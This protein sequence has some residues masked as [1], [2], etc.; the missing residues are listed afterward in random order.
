MPDTPSRAAQLGAIAFLL[1]LPCVL[2]PTNTSTAKIMSHP[3]LRHL[4]HISYS[5]FCC[6]VLVLY[7]AAPRLGFELFQSSPVLLFG[8]I[9]G[10]SLFVS[11]VLY[12]C[13]E[14]PFL[15]LKSWRSSKPKQSTPTANATHP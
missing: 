9:L 7:I 5:L 14:I 1:I 3:F 8:V 4:G 6:H 2:G 15:K 11:E 13:V 12:R 10:I